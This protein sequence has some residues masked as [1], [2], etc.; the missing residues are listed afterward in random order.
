MTSIPLVSVEPLRRRR[1]EKATIP[2]CAVEVCQ[3][4]SS[5]TEA[6]VHP[7][8]LSGARNVVDVTEQ[9]CFL[10]T[11]MSPFHY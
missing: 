3:E 11:K 10:L 6:E 8:W 9:L 7:S 1:G 4:D 2:E 5:L